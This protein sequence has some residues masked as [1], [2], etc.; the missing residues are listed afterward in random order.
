MDEVT[1]QQMC[2]RCQVTPAVKDKTKCEPCL[3]QDRDAWRKKYYRSKKK[4]V[5]SQAHKDAIAEGRKN[6]F[7]KKDK[8]EKRPYKRRV[9]VAD[10]QMQGIVN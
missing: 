8:G 1:G 3:Q 5:L 10:V 7:A 4:R 9:E 6:A 2:S